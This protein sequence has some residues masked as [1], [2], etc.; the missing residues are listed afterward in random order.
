MTVYPHHKYGVTVPQKISTRRLVPWFVYCS[1]VRP[2]HTAV[3]DAI[4]RDKGLSEAHR[5]PPGAPPCGQCF[6]PERG[7]KV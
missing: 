7:L 1:A 4:S 5:I 2:I 3:F 6:G